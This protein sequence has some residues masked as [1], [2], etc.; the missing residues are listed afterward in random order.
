MI[1]GAVLGSAT[2]FIESTVVNVALPAIGL[3]FALGVSGLQWI[4][5]GY[6][7]PLSGLLLLGGALG[8][9]HGLKRA[10]EAGLILFAAAT[11]WCGLAPGYPSLVAAR[12]AQGAAG[13]LLVPTSLAFLDTAFADEDRS[14][15][16]GLW[17][18]WSAVATALGPL[19]GGVLVDVASW[20]WVFASVMPLPLL[21]L[22][23]SRRR[24]ARSPPPPPRRVDW[25]GALLVS[26]SLGALV[27]AL[28]EGP[29]RGP[30]PAVIGAG[31]LGLALG[32]AFLWFESR[33][34]APL[35]PWA[36]LR[37]R[38]FSGANATTLLVYTAIG[39][40][41]F[42]LMIEL[43]AV[44]G[45]SALA[46]GA[47]LLPINLL[48]MTL[49]RRSGRWGERSGPRTPIAVGALLAA[50]GLALFSRVGPGSTYVTT[51]LPATVVFGAGL[52]VLVA[53]LTASV[54]AVSEEGRV[55][56]AS[57]FNNAIARLGGLLATALIP[58]AA[59]IGGLD[60]WSGPAFAAAFRRAMWISVA[61]SGLGGGLAW[62]TV[63]R[64]GPAPAGPHP[65]PTHGCTV[66]APFAEVLKDG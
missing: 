22:W 49:S 59:G 44:L 51:V 7:I 40:L 64:S 52:A 17:A 18:G 38:Q 8:D 5:N 14:E 11:F 29:R 60:D 30:V 34:R 28:I 66:R 10:F 27:W 1:A 13:A 25:I 58:L 41:F 2:V 57:A 36:M 35:L 61:L 15:A 62:L 47:A 19:L 42:F 20:R 48:M 45:Y 37:S 54:L 63:T 43:Q 23:I 46:A 16:I 32:S 21:A 4:V 65:S 55:G 6:L 31:V 26:T 39:A 3:D 56:V 50:A 24:L 12:F 33:Q 53:P 9:G